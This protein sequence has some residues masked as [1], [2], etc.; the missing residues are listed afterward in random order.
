MSTISMNR[1]GTTIR[2]IDQSATTNV[3]EDTLIR[4]LFLQLF[5]SDKGPENLRTVHGND[6][7]KLYGSTP[8][9]KKH[10]QPLLQAA[11][12]V[13]AGGELLCKRVVAEDAT[14]ANLVIVA[15]VSS[16]QTQK[17]D[18][19][20]KPLYIDATTGVETTDSNGGA[21][22][23]V[24]INVAKV[25]YD[26]ISIKGIKSINEVKAYAST[27]IKDELETE[28]T[29]YDNVTKVGDP[30]T[31]QNV[32]GQVNDT[33]DEDFDKYIYP[34]FVVT[35]NGRGT[36]SKRF[37][38]T[39]DYTIS[40][41]LNF[42]LYRLNFIGDVE[43]ENEYVWFN[44]RDD[45]I[46]LN[47][48]MSLDMIA[49][50]LSQI[51][52]SSF[53]DSIEMF[54]NRLADITGIDVNELKRLDA[55][56][57]TSR[58]GEALPQITVDK[59]GYILNSTL[60]MTL[61][62]GDNGS[63]GANPIEAATYGEEMVKVLTGVY[64]D[65]IYDKDRFMIDV[66]MDANYPPE[67]KTAL[68]DLAVYREDFMYFRDYGLEAT[69]YEDI[70][71]IHFDYPKSKFVADYCQA[72]DII[73]SWTKKRIT[74]TAPFSI[75]PKLVTHLND[76]RSAPVCGILYDFVFSDVI[77]GSVTF[78]P[79]VT[80]NVDQ[81]TMLAD[82]N[83]NYASY[84]NNALTLETCFTAQDDEIRSQLGW[85]NNILAVTQIIH[86]IRTECPKIRYS[87]ITDSDLDK[88]QEDVNKV[89]LRNKEDFASI[90]MEYTQDEIMA[91][92]KIFEADIFV[93]FRNFEQEE[94]FNIYTLS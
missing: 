80:P 84:V 26:A 7:F 61:Q 10:G 19:A 85:I 39:P 15:K 59:T 54:V 68:Y 28:F 1:P 49:T 60:G 48:S 21:N 53:A 67:V 86:N 45:V 4:P 73:D 64:D 6:F 55:I 13:K 16:E 20:G 57:G 69:T 75:A 51:K 11:E 42:Q 83:I 71:V 92:N 33:E 40:K 66:A 52:A 81:K 34:L 41:A 58:K 78:L 25:K 24:L 44:F 91:A 46:Y 43:G 74:V 94:I 82:S 31:D 32:V 93:R 29:G 2:L 9:F 90:Y 5:T 36:S 56:F 23:R 35:D 79:K 89:I 50:E 63:F 88:Y 18:S 30:L 62:E 8:S 12:I 77:E 17:T 87:F 65:S 70:A 27:I 72:W 22:E 14:L 38:I 37:N 3:V 76:R 47:K